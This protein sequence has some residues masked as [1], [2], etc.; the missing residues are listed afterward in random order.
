MKILITYDFLSTNPILGMNIVKSLSFMKKILTS[1]DIEAIVDVGNFPQNEFYECLDIELDSKKKFTVLNIDKLNK[2]TF[3]L[4]NNHVKEFDLLITYELSIE[5]RKLFDKYKIKYIDLWLSPIRFYDDLMFNFYSNSH[6]IHNNLKKYQLNE[7][8]F[9]ETSQKI[10]NQFKYFMCKDLILENNSI[11]L[12]GQLFEDRSV[13]KNGK[14]LTLIDYKNRIK[15]LSESYKKIYLQKH[16]F[17]SEKDF[18]IYTDNFMDVKNMEYLDNINT[19]ELLSRNEIQKVVGISS[20]VLYEAKFFNKEI[21]YLYKSVI[22]KDSIMIYKEYFKTSFWSDILSI[23]S[24]LNIEL[25]SYD[26]YF[27]QK[28]KAFWAYEDIMDQKFSYKEESYKTMIKIFNFLENLSKSREYVIYGYGS[29]GQL[30][31]AYLKMKNIKVKA[32]I[33]KSLINTTTINEYLILNM[34]ELT[35][36]DNVIITP[37][38]YNNE[39][40][41]ELMI[42]TKNIIEINFN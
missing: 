1:L 8:V 29:I 14:F 18:A 26:N 17:M 36:D 9:F 41:K 31:L 34:T 23:K 40:K 4:V 10:C 38:I 28:L 19:Y 7:N 33:D 5:T 13:I 42:Y 27:R 25:L 2:K 11:L 30:I 20:S 12:I 37:F 24:D 16:P 6:E 3:N 22:N 21:E 39:I 15:E 32:I 35:E